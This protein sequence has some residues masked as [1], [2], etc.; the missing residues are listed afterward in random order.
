LPGSENCERINFITVSP[1]E[2]YLA[3]CERGER[4]Q[5]SI[6]DLNHKKKKKVLPDYHQEVDFTS[7]EFVSAAFSPKNDKGHA[8]LVTLVGDPDWCLIFWAWDTCKILARVNLNIVGGADPLT[9]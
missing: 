9:F 6:W 5:C 8:H 2:R 4:A 7:Q 3:I 1:N